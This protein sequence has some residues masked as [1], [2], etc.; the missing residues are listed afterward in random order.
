[1]SRAV[2]T[3]AQGQAPGSLAAPPIFPAGCGR[4]LASLGIPFTRGVVALAQPRAVSLVPHRRPNRRG[5]PCGTA[6]N[7]EGETLQK[8]TGTRSSNNSNYTHSPLVV[9]VADQ[10][11]CSIPVAFLRRALCGAGS[12]GNKGRGS[13]KGRGMGVCPC[14]CSRRLLRFALSAGVRPA[15]RRGLSVRAVPSAAAAAAAA[16]AGSATEEGT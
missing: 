14:V 8:A 4:H 15:V 6:R 1:M 11:V 12:V 3:F 13:R 2:E 10:S 5:A 9:C 16:A 7:E